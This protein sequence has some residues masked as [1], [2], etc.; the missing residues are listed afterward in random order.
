MAAQNFKYV[1]FG[2]L[3]LAIIGVI[4]TLFIFQDFVV[5]NLIWIAIL[6]FFAFL[7][8]KYDFI[9]Q[10]VDYERAVIYRFGKV[11]RVG[12]PGWA[13]VWPVIESYAEVDLRVKTIDVPKQHV[14]TKDGVEVTVDAVVYLKVKKDNQSVVNSVIEVE[15]YVDAS[16]LYIISSLRDVV[17]SMD[18]SD[19]I[20]NIEIINAKIKENLEQMSKN[21]GITID[22]IEIKDVEIPEIV[23]NAMHEQKAAVQQK[24][25]RMERALGQKAE[26]EAVREATAHLDDKALAY[27]YIKAI[28]G[29][30]NSKGSKVF[31]PSEFSKLAESFTNVADGMHKGSSKLAS[32]NEYY[33]TLLKGYIDGAVKKAKG[34]STPVRSLKKSKKKKK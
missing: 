26:I 23:L 14:V 11:H 4:Y 24:L 5:T 33:K 27:Y 2:I 22:S 12:G 31:F 1:V 18:L 7:V 10:L 13:W 20:S 32:K 15:D 16:Q 25:G 3:I 19:V 30:G 29:L 34:S 21:W 8:Y 6:V 17:G 9:L 28:E